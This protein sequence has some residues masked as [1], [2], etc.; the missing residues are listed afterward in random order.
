M[1]IFPWDAAY[2]VGL[3]KVD[4][5]H[6]RLVDIV[7]RL[8]E[9]ISSGNEAGQITGILQELLDYTRYH[10]TTEERLM[11]AAPY[12]R[13]HYLRHKREH[14]AF[15]EKVLGFAGSMGG[16]G[17]PDVAHSLLNYLIHWLVAHILGADRE[18]ARFLSNPAAT[19]RAD[20]ETAQRARDLAEAE[21]KLIAA[22]TESEWRFRAL[23]DNAPV[24]IWMSTAA[25]QRVFFNKPWADFTGE[26]R[27]R[28][29]ERWRD[30]LDAQ[31]V[32]RCEQA[33]GVQPPVPVTIEYRLR[34]ADGS[35]RWMLETAVPRVS[36]GSFAGYVGSC[37]DIT[38]RKAYEQTLEREVAERTAALQEAKEKLERD[39][40]EQQALITKLRDAQGQLLQSEKMA[41]IGQ[42][43]AG[44]AH[45]INNPVG[46]VKSNLNT[47][48]SYAGDLLK[49]AD[50]VM[51]DEGEAQ[52]VCAGIDLPFIR[53]DLES[54]LD[55]TRE[56]I[57]RVQHIV[58]DL[59]EFSHVDQ[60]EWQVADLHK[61]LESTLNLVW[62]EL[63]YKATIVRDYGDLP[64][65]P[66]IARQLNQV[67]MNL[68]VNAAQAIQERGTITLRTRCQGDEA[69]IEISDTGVGI[70]PEH[71]NRLFEPFYTTKPIGQGT[72]LGL[73]IAYGIMERH[74]GRIEVDSTLGEGTTFR[75]RLP[76]DRPA[77]GEGTPSITTQ[78][79]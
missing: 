25:G 66:C 63:K 41:S 1:A 22:L 39:K 62:N 58:Q 14:D 11:L 5:Q 46:Y 76:L 56:G 75:L 26:E 16:G 54:L 10:F 9:A 20:E 74:G 49:L 15:V 31:D 8:D 60:T 23:A 52:R 64:P 37:L 69:V 57:E 36:E 24:L 50:A 2:C 28:L 7:N 27:E 21:R 44:V 73:S 34:R 68:L 55:E 53:Q 13:A 32:A 35:Y 77:P 47:L 33:Y 45:E 12:M 78:A 17:A 61:G 43:A 65:I 4:R 48:A 67:F 42:L 71:L 30:L 18:M 3:D 70:P 6:Q 19:P 40:A 79:V 29:P 72:G 59:R 38:D 51:R